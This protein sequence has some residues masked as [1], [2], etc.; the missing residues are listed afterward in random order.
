MSGDYAPTFDA[1]RN[2]LAALLDGWVFGRVMREVTRPDPHKPYFHGMIV[3]SKG[4]RIWFQQSNVPHRSLSLGPLGLTPTDS[5]P[6]RAGDILMGKVEPA[7]GERHKARL[8]TWYANVPQIA[9]LAKVCTRGTDKHEMQLLSDMRT[10]AN[11]DI[12]ALVRLVL[13]GNIGAFAAAHRGK[14]TMRLSTTPLEFVHSAAETL[15]DHTIWDAFLALVPDAKSP[16]R[17]PPPQPYLPTPHAYSPPFSPFTLPPAHP[18]TPTPQTYVPISPPFNPTTP[19]SSPPFN[20]TT[21]P[22]TPPSSP[23]TLDDEKKKTED[24]SRIWELLKGYIQI[25]EEYDPMN[26]T[27]AGL[28]LK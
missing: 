12:W 6:P 5:T 18:Y 14:G 7:R 22:T 11:D 25:Q 3:T 16:K 24:A 28:S 9:A 15:G 19:P 2:T 20:P 1:A 27:Y 8:L 23:P 26:P 21:P 10:T 17:L 13:F 4:D